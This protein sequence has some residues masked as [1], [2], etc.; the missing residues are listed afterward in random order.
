MFNLI[1][2]FV[3]VLV[4]DNMLYYSTSVVTCDRK[5]WSGG[6]QDQFPPVGSTDSVLCFQTLS[7]WRKPV[8]P[9]EYW[10][11]PS[12]KSAAVCLHLN[13]PQH[14]WRHCDEQ[15]VHVAMMLRVCLFCVPDVLPVTAAAPSPL[16]F[17]RTTS[18]RKL[19]ERYWHTPAEEHLVTS[20]LVMWCHEGSGVSCC[21]ITL[22]NIIIVT[23]HNYMLL[24]EESDK[25]DSTRFIVMIYHLIEWI[26]ERIWEQNL[27]IQDYKLLFWLFLWLFLFSV[28]MFCC[29]WPTRC[30]SC[31]RR[32]KSKNVFWRSN[33]PG[34]SHTHLNLLLWAVRSDWQQSSVTVAP[35]SWLVQMN[36]VSVGEELIN[37]LFRVIIHIMI[38]SHDTIELNSRPQI[39]ERREYEPPH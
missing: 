35:H 24:N 2:G 16:C 7:C 21:D 34:E 3:V 9:K 8:W 4:P 5:S 32:L 18:W 28:L 36:Q 15:C 30:W 37:S 31:S 23:S 14:T 22:L 12:G 39:R 33:M 10:A 38:A 20:S 13:T 1:S 25:S 17:T 29:S 6:N 19:Q 26:C 27:N 11:A